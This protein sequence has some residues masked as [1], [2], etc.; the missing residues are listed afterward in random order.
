M[1]VITLMSLFFAIPLFSYSPVQLSRVTSVAFIISAILSLNIYYVDVIGYGLSLYSG[2][3]HISSVSLGI[4]IFILIVG[5]I[6]V[7]P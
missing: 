2:L 4:E 7:L 1:L 3:F 6:I 5:G